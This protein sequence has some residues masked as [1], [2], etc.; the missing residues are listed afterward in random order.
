MKPPKPLKKEKYKYQ[1]ILKRIYNKKT[2]N[3]YITIFVVKYLI[4]YTPYMNIVSMLNFG[5]KK[6]IL[7]LSSFYI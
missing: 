3:I 7:L 2:L 1:I 4:G 6:I 5:K